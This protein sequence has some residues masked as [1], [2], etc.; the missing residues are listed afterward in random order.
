MRIINGVANIIGG[1]V[2]FALKGFAYMILGSVV[3][4]ILLTTIIGMIIYTM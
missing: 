2:S 4:A 1:F 3:G